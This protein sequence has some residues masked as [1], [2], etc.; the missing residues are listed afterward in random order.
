MENLIIRLGLTLPT[1][2]MIIQFLFIKKLLNEIKYFEGEI[3]EQDE[4]FKKAADKSAE[5]FNKLNEIMKKKDEFIHDLMNELEEC[6]D[7]VNDMS[8]RQITL[9]SKED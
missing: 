4:V 3:Q 1:I 8:E 2:V 5:M 6:R 7:K 9:N